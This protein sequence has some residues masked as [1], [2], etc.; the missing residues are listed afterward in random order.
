M[1]NLIISYISLFHPFLLLSV[2]LHFFLWIIWEG[3]Q[4]GTCIGFEIRLKTKPMPFNFLA[5]QLLEAVF[6]IHETVMI[7]TSQA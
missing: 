6:P 7:P 3:A 4:N 2:F 1:K 5:L